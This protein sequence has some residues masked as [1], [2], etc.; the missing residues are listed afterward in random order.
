[1]SNSSR[2]LLQKAKAFD[3]A[4]TKGERKKVFQSDNKKGE[5]PSR[6]IN[7]PARSKE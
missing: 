1:L 3:V 7:N 6:A 4:P 5:I 2:T